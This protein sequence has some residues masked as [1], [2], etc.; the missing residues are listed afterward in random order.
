MSE[1]TASSRHAAAEYACSVS[2]SDNVLKEQGGAAHAA[3]LAAARGCGVCSRLPL[4]QHLLGGSRAAL[5]IQ[6]DRQREQRKRTQGRVCLL[7]AH[8][9]LAMPLLTREQ[10]SEVKEGSCVCLVQPHGAQ[11][12]LLRLCQATS[13]EQQIAC[14]SCISRM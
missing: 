7:K 13:P 8:T 12:R 14:I 11:E 2:P 9:R 3:L 1:A 4:W 6:R 5:K 10:V